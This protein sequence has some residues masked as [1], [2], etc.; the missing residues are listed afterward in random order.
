MAAGL[1]IVVTLTRS[2]LSFSVS[3]YKQSGYMGKLCFK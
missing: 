1:E 3:A 2:A